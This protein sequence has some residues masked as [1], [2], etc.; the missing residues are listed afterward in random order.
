MLLGVLYGNDVNAMTR[1]DFVEHLPRPF[2]PWTGGRPG[3]GG[4]CDGI[5]VPAD[6]GEA[7]EAPGHGRPHRATHRRL[8]NGR[9]VRGVVFVGVI[10]RDAFYLLLL[11]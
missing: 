11:Q 4:G 7:D 3:S 2:P 5:A 8:H 6:R 9:K 10:S 1:C